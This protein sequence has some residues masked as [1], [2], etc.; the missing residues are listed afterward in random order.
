MNKRSCVQRVLCCLLFAVMLVSSLSAV[1][2]LDTK[3]AGARPSVSYV[4]HAQSY[5]WMQTKKDGENA[6]TTGEGKRLEAIAIALDLNGVMA[7]DGTVMTGGLQYRVHAQSYGWMNWVDADAN[8]ATPQS[9]V[10]RHEYAGTMG[11]GKRLEAIQIKLTGKLAEEYEVFYRVHMQTYGWSPWTRDGQ[12][13]GTTGQGKRLEAIQ[14]KLVDKADEEPGATISYSV[15][16]QSYGWMNPVGNGQTA[17]TTGQGKRLEAIKIQL[18]TTGVTGGI[19]YSTHVQNYGWMKTVSDGTVSGT[20]GQA[21]RMEAIRISLTG[22]ISAYYDIYYRVHCQSYGWLDWA[23]NGQAAG[24]ES[25]GKRMEAIQIKLVK[26]GEAAPGKTNRPFVTVIPKNPTKDT[27]VIKINREAC[28]VTI[29]RDGV[30]VKAMACSPGDATPTGT[31][32]IGGQW[33][34]NTLMG[35]VQ[36][37][38]CSQISGN[39]L[40]HSVLFTDRNPR[41][42]ITSSFN[43]LGKRVSHGCVRLRVVDAKWIFDNCPPG[44]KIIIYNSADPGPLGKPDYGTIPGGQTWDPSDP[45]L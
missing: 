33:R 5:G 35:G 44:T 6:G 39:V 2:V 3:A 15:H 18:Q 20:S 41:T 11:Q 25:G 19:E 28:C 21:K 23:K 30:P 42:L 26:K 12:T 24:T 13:A 38:Y 8:G 40:F 37:Q 27:Y 43:N 9:L 22:D 45:S 16:A 10:N 4:V 14:I 34:W 1:P 32:S 29:Y 7:E 36:G 31:F 17:G